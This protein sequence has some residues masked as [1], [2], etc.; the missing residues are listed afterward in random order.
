MNGGGVRLVGVW[1]C[2]WDGELDVDVDVDVSANVEL[3]G[4]AYPMA[5]QVL[6]YAVL[7]VEEE[8]HLWTVVLSQE[9]LPES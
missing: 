2:R 6:G 4:A 1:I 9:S 3:G 7:W 5:K 8:V